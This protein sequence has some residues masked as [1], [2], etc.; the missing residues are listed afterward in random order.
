MREINKDIL[1]RGDI[2]LLVNRFYEKVKSDELLQPIFSQID[3]PSHLPT[4]YNF[5]SSMLL[6]DQTYQGN[7][8]LKHLKLPIDQKHF[9]RWLELFRET[10]TE[11][12]KG[13]KA[14][15]AKIRAQSIA[16]IFQYK[17][18]LKS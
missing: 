1:Q 16:D 12:F 3:W 9:R 11:N 5:W 8:L 15:E 18:E 2:E 10:V 14:E 13:E 4:M 17:M 6:G 7:P